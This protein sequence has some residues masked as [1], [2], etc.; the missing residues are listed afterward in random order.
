MLE[1]HHGRGPSVPILLTRRGS[2][3]R[4]AGATVVEL[5]I[6]LPVAAA[7]FAHVVVLTVACPDLVSPWPRRLLHGLPSSVAAI[8]HASGTRCGGC[9]SF[10][11]LY[12]VHG[13]GEWEEDED[14]REED[15]D[16]RMAMAVVPTVC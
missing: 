3:S 13:G 16:E 11:V 8:F 6:P 14:E 2:S 4:R 10:Y 15:E 5:A 12:C 9:G 1:S 7:S